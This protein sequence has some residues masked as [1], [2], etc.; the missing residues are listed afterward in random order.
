[1]FITDI[2]QLTN[3][4]KTQQRLA[5]NLNSPSKYP[6]SSNFDFISKRTSRSISSNSSKIQEKKI[7]KNSRNSSV[8]ISEKVL[9]KKIKKKKRVTINFSAEVNFFESEQKKFT[10]F[11]N[12]KK[13]KSSILEVLHDDDPENRKRSQT[14]K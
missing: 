6:G 4:L 2:S 10:K 8:Y 13:I 12:G 1:M 14:N 5:S 9:S 7:K 11:V 3:I